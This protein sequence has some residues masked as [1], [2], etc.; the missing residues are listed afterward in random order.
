MSSL[1]DLTAYIAPFAERYLTLLSVHPSK[2][3]NYAK[4]GLYNLPV[5]EFSQ[6]APKCKRGES[7]LYFATPLKAS[8]CNLTHQEQLYVGA[9]TQDRMFRGDGMNGKNYHH[10][11]MRN[12]NGND[13]PVEFLASGKQIGIYRLTGKLIEEIVSQT[14]ELEPLNIL[15]QQPRTSRRHLGWWYEQYVLHSEQG[16]WR[17]NTASADQSV[18]RLFR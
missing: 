12:G 1:P 18:V 13:N 15:A 10:S 11:E 16:R 9:Q 6:H 5:I 17:W 4:R 8:L 2:F 7:W 3:Y 14:P